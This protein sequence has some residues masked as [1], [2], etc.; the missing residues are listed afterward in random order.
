MRRANLD[1]LTKELFD[2]TIIGCGITGSAIARDA[3]LRGLKV[4]VIEKD[5][6]ASG[7]SSRSSK[8]IHGGLRYLETY[9]FGLVAESVREREMAL[10]LAPHLTKLQPFMYMFYDDT[11]DKKWLLNLG[12]TFYDLVSGSWNTRRHKMLNKQ[13]VLDRQ[14]QF[15]PDGLNGAAMF[16]DVSTDDARV[17]IDT[18]KGACE[19]GA[20]LI[21]HCKVVGLTFDDYRCNGVEVKDELNQKVVSIRSHYVVNATGPWSD[22]ILRHEQPDSKVLRPTKGVHIV[23][24]KQDF[25]LHSAV[26]MRS[27]DD[28]RVVWPIPSLQDDRVFIGTTDTTYEGDLNQ[29]YPEKSDI[30]Y[31]LNVANHLMPGAKLDEKDVVGSWAGLRPLIAPKGELNNSKTPRE[32]QIL[33]SKSGVFSIVG[34]K[35]TS[36]RV[37]AKQLLDKLVKH[38]R[39]Q[40]LSPSLLPYRAD[41]VVISGASINDNIN[42][43]EHAQSTRKMKYEHN[44]LLAVLTDREVPRY[45][46]EPWAKRFGYNALKV[47]DIYVSD[48]SYQRIV[49]QRGLTVAEIR[50]CVLHEMACDLSDLLIRRTSEFFWD[51]NGGVEQVGV[52]A[53]VMQSLLGW[54][55]EEKTEQIDRYCDLVQAHRPLVLDVSKIL[56]QYD[57]VE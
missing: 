49:S 8:L 16:Y 33:Q 35:L 55:E 38:D 39:H 45:V 12:L 17:T 14:P 26:F 25:P 3:A 34:G 24:R 43:V 20:Q 36:N 4:L 27:P 13:Q 5:D 23:L 28:G 52:I 19:Q 21:N 32:H 30:R 9:Q 10:K 54:T 37:M 29:V 22:D 56:R 48:P 6:I 42:T 46:A 15:R 7:T 53:A 44:Y 47:A 50:Y 11:P 1:H 41:K 2:I 40:Y 18:M 51:K 31:L 57:T